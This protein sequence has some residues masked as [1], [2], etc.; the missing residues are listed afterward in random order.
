MSTGLEIAV[1]GLAGRF[2]GAADADAYWRNLRDG[3]DGITRFTSDEAMTWGVPAAVARD[4]GFVGAHGILTEADCFDHQFFGLNPREAAV[5]DPQHR[6]F[7]ECCHAALEDAGYDPQR[8]SGLV[9]VFA[10]SSENDYLHHN[11]LRNPG[12]IAGYGSYQASVANLADFLATTVSY[13]LGLRGPSLNLRTACSTSLVAVHLACQ[14]LLAGACDAAIAGGV[15]LR[16]PNRRGYVYSEGHILSP[17]GLCRAFSDD[18]AGAIAGD[19]VG[20]VV[21]KRLAD[22]LADGDRID[23][24][25][26][27]S[28]MNNDGH[29]KAGFTAPGLSGQ[30]EV[31]RAAHLAAG[32]TADE[33]GYVE[34]HGTGTPVG[35][36]I[37]VGAL[38]QAFGDLP[39]GS[40]LIGS[41]K[42]NI[43][44]LDAAAGIAGF[45]KAVLAVRH[46][47]IPPSLH[48]RQANPA[49]DFAAG[50]FAV[51]AALSAWPKGRPRIAGVSSYGMGGTNAHVIVGEA[52]TTSVV[53]PMVTPRLFMLSARSA[54]AA[55]R[56]AVT[57]AE[58][59]AASDAP[60]PAAAART[61]ATGRPR[62][63]H[64][65][66]AVAAT[67]AEAALRLRAAI[68]GRAGEQSR[69]VAL[70]LPGQGAQ[71]GRMAAGLR[72]DDP[73]VRDAWR[74]ACAALTPH[75]GLDLSRV[76]DATDADAH[77]RETALAQPALLALHWA[78]AARW[79]AWGVTID[80]LVGHSIG[81]I[82]AAA[83]AGALSLSDAARLVALR[84]RL[85]QAMPPGVMLAVP[86]PLARLRALAGGGVAVAAENAAEL[87]VLSG[88]AEA[89][90]AI[91]AHLVAEG[92]AAKRLH[93]SHA[94]HSPAMAPIAA[95][96]R[97]CVA[98]LAWRQPQIAI[99]S[100]VTATW[101][102]AATLANP[103]HWIANALQPVRF[104]AALDLLLAAPN[105]VLVEAGPPVLTGL[106]RRAPG[107]AG[108]HLA[109]A[110]LPSVTSDGDDRVTVLEALGRLWCAGVEPDIEAAFPA[111]CTRTRLP[112]YPFARNRHWIEPATAD[113]APAK[114]GRLPLARWFTR[115][116]WRTAGPPIATNVGPLLLI[117][118][119]GGLAEAL[120]K[121]LVARGE[122]VHRLAVDS[123]SPD[124]HERVA[125]TMQEL[126]IATVVD[127]RP[128]D[129]VGDPTDP[130]A[131]DHA[132]AVAVTGPLL[133]AQSVAR[134]PG[135]RLR[136]VMV[137]ANACAVLGDDL[138]HPALATAHG[139]ARVLPQEFA[140]WRS[141][142][143]D[144]DRRP[145]AADALD[146]L[147]SEALGPLD[148]PLVALRG[149]ARLVEDHVAVALPTAE[150]APVDVT[151]AWLIT[152]GLGG[153]GLTLAAALV[154]RG[155]RG[156]ALLG[157]GGVGDDPARS[158]AV[159]AL[160]AAGARVVVLAAD[161]ADPVATR[162]ALDAARAA[163]G[164]VVGVV[165]AAGVADDRMLAAKEPADWQR[166]FAP[167]LRGTAT[168]LA[169]FGDQPPATV[170]FASSLASALGGIGRADYCGA[171][172]TL[173]AYAH[174]LRQRG[175]RAV[176]IGWDG[177][178]DVGMATR[179]PAPDHLRD[180][181]ADLMADAIAPSEGA[182]VFLRALAGD[183]AQV[184]VSTRDFTTLARSFA[185]FTRTRVDAPAAQS[186]AGREGLERAYVLPATDAERAVAEAWQEMLGVSPIGAED[187][188][189]ELGGHSLLA[190]QVASRLRTRLAVEVP[191]R[192]LLT[193][194]T[195]RGW[196]ALFAATRDEVEL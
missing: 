119:R 192:A 130:V 38:N 194:P 181:M 170:V 87:G 40:C 171:N 106:A 167:K 33:V 56:L 75:L 78:L 117:D 10:G 62:F 82:S 99:A 39:R 4:A 52:P 135:L 93:T 115:P 191:L 104:A 123:A 12:V 146:R 190:T 179:L 125:A 1:I 134:R 76:V 80:A 120:A 161:I 102:D 111:A 58:A 31:I 112:T 100:T 140:G 86:L 142:A 103:E 72:R 61:L 19:G 71:H 149:A 91:E 101:V 2:P 18:A 25:V 188:F 28:A 174:W 35:D 168:L 15:S 55:D 155:V 98:G 153:I 163:L 118:D 95:Q 133:L 22:A 97:E 185:E 3:V 166:V 16:L 48:F 132:L 81:E 41:V 26:L 187:D 144:L 107:F 126:G 141:T 29:D 96:L 67:A 37:E 94:F 69:R 113:S 114:G 138:L 53:A 92:V 8:M 63:T 162:A 30:A 184:L 5:R 139:P 88:P 34:A 182:E 65:R 129:A 178:R 186:G 23:A 21:L 147:A 110:S 131:A 105:R 68:A 49:I 177:W 109:V 50:P 150:G 70:L 7:L 172:A 152:G 90:A 195:V 193:T 165:H 121:R 20:A 157:R 124:D 128:L 77:L 108:E 156:L 176:A 175:V 74:E 158:A 42:T 32:I 24:V 89:I 183:E 66:V 173:D 11:V 154:A 45:L 164:R 6:V 36:P 46:A 196:A 169:A 17:D 54:E 122:R 148:V 136:L 83:I 47:A 151:G 143:I 51:A 73:V 159:A 57:T 180:V 84:G 27:G 9:G 44:H 160:E 14:A 43:G 59:M 60:E 13:H 127:C 137:T 189:F 145:G 64:R 79:R 116:G 85:M